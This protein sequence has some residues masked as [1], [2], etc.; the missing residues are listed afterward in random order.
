[1]DKKDKK[2]L[3]NA[4]LIFGFTI[5][6]L[7]IAIFVEK[8]MTANLI[9]EQEVYGEWLKDNCNCTEYERIK[10]PEGFEWNAERHWCMDEG[11]LTNP[12]MGCSRYDCEGDIKIWNNRKNIWEDSE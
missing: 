1:M 12:R 7:V 3:R 9:K 5:L 10:C 11:K 8:V 6:L 4:I 2:L